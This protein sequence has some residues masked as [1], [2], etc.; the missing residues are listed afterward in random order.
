M[1]QVRVI[2]EN[3]MERLGAIRWS[4][5]WWLV[6]PGVADK[7]EINFDTDLDCNYST[8]RTKSAAMK[9][10]KRVAGES[11]FGCAMVREQ[12]VAWLD[13]ECYGIAEWADAGDGEEVRA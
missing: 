12:F 3:R 1:M 9:W 8:H 5:E 11:F 2:P 6:R 10:A 13:D 7:E 4:V